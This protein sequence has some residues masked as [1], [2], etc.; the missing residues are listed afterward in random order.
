MVSFDTSWSCFGDLKATG[1]FYS[2]RNKIYKG[3]GLRGLSGTKGRSIKRPISLFREIYRQN[4][5]V[6]VCQ[7]NRI[8]LCPSEVYL[9]HNN[10]S[11]KEKYINR[12]LNRAED[13]VVTIARDVF[14]CWNLS[15]LK[16]HKMSIIDTGE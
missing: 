5:T 14:V 6:F 13:K 11:V 4:I 15:R 3:W 9:F 8:E 16:L 12:L 1:D 2:K 10:Q 7:K